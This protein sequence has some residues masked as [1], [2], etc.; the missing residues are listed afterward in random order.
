MTQQ[1]DPGARVRHDTRMGRGARTGRNQRRR[2]GCGCSLILLVS[3]LVGLVAAV[4]VGLRWYLSDRAEKEVS[5]QIDAP[6]D[7]SF[8]SGLLLWEV[9]TTRT[10]EQVHLTSPGS[11]GVPR[12]DVTG[13]SV[14]LVDG[15]IH[16]GTVDGTAVL[17]EQQLAAAAAQ[18]D[19]VQ[20]S[21]IAGL[22]E[23]RSV[24]PDAP[25][26]LLRA[27][28]GGIAEIG[29]A[30]GVTAGQLTLRPE[31]TALLGFPLPDGLFSGITTVV[32]STL[33]TLPQ[34][35]VIEGARVVPEGLEV[36]LGGRDVVVNQ[37]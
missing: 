18:G 12:L 30:P 6:V 5:A 23:I 32:D 19:P 8:G 7:I 15:A 22:T 14:G 9:L 13:H 37:N 25:A 24:R 33:A 3:I 36:S 10:A 11:E 4:E 17:D 20:E 2:G 29:V 27:D 1:V 34:G 28:I 16:A 35:L 21:P 31:Q 26:G